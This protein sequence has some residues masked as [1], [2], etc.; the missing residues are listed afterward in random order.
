MIVLDRDGVINFDSPDFILAPEQWN[1]L[2]GSLD[3]IARLKRAG[4][5]ICVATNQSG[6]GRGLMSAADLDAIHSRMRTA[7]AEAGGSIDHIVVC[8]HAPDDDCNC[9][10]PLA[11]LFEMLSNRIGRSLD[12]APSVGDSERDLVASETAGALPML[13]LT[14]NGRKTAGTAAGRR[15]AQFKDL[16]AVVDRLL[17]SGE[18][19]P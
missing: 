7:V 5:V 16:A 18:A 11:G 3:A 1:P 6:V 17:A 15:A 4:Y 10:K 2:P 13:V 12:G 19:D 14:G 9:R 8:P